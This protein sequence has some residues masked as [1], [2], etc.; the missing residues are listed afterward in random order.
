MITGE[1]YA[2][3]T[4][5]Q[6]KLLFQLR[7]PLFFGTTGFLGCSAVSFFNSD[8]LPNTL[9]QIRIHRRTCFNPGK[10][11]IHLFQFILKCLIDF[12][13]SLDCYGFVHQAADDVVLLGMPGK[14]NLCFDQCVFFRRNSECQSITPFAVISES[15][16]F[17][18]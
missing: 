1:C 3:V 15:L 13:I 8:S 10:F 6:G 12:R 18:R 11:I 4:I 16:R 17:P 14:M 5:N 7:S 2:P 9:N